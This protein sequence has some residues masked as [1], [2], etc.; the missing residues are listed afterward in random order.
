MYVADRDTFNDVF[1]MECGHIA[2]RETLNTDGLCEDCRPLSK[3]AETNDSFRR[4]AMKGIKSTEGKAVRTRG[5][6]ALGSL[7]N[8]FLQAQI[9][10]FDAFT[11]TNDPH[12]EHDFGCVQLDGCPKVFWK[13][14]YYSDASM[15]SGADD[16]LNAY[17][18]L[19]IMLADEY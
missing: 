17:R 1:C 5:V 15:D 11:E 16:K 12:G 3:I 6:A 4:A 2:G 9:A 13:I 14:D 8:L 7:T 10:A 18:V 19:V